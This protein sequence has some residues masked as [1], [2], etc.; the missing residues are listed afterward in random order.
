MVISAKALSQGMLGMSE[1]RPTRTFVILS[2]V[3]T[4]ERAVGDGAEGRA[5]M[6]R[7]V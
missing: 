6:N 2:S 3:D 5:R 7:A 4:T 1:G